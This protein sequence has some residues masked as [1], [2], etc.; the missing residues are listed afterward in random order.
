MQIIRTIAAAPA[1]TVAATEEATTANEN[2]GHFSP[3]KDHS[4]VINLN[5]H[6]HVLEDWPFQISMTLIRKKS[7][8]FFFYMN[9][10]IKFLYIEININY[11]Y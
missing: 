6:D 3:F 1:T 7:S 10:C 9:I 8:L 5:D 4:M 2:A 11:H